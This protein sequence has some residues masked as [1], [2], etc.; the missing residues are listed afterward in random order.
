MKDSG[1]LHAS[2]ARCTCSE[3]FPF[4]SDGNR[5]AWARPWPRCVDLQ[6]VMFTTSLPF[7]RSSLLRQGPR[8][9]HVF[10]TC[11]HL[12]LRSVAYGRLL[13]T[14]SG[15]ERGKY[16]G[17]YLA[18]GYVHDPAW[19]GGITCEWCGYTATLIGESI[20]SSYA[21]VQ[22]FQFQCGRSHL[23]AAAVSCSTVGC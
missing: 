14:P 19:E 5:C 22:K 15:Q 23:F 2:R 11:T 21:E 17:R 18:T 1:Q 7:E 20:R 13:G 4:I 12:S 3:S 9:A 16:F 8:T 6:T 10:N